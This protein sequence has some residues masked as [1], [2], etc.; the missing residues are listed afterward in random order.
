M[1]HQTRAKL[2]EYTIV[3]NVKWRGIPW[4]WVVM[5]SV[6]VG[7]VGYAIGLSVGGG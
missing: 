6:I 4:F 1:T 5:Y 7:I 2:N 3:E